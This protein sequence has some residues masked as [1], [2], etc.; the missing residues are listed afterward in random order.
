MANL[1]E[2]PTEIWLVGENELATL[3]KMTGKDEVSIIREIITQ[4]VE[5]EITEDGCEDIG[6]HLVTLFER[7]KATYLP[8]SIA[9]DLGLRSLAK[10]AAAKLIG[11]LVLFSTLDDCPQCGWETESYEDGGYGHT[12]TV[13]KCNNS[14]CDFYESDEPDFPDHKDYL[15][16]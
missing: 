5:N 16:R 15:N 11:E 7:E 1:K 12:W 14:D 8:I 13:R 4:L 2:V 9:W 6:T 3:S 10:F